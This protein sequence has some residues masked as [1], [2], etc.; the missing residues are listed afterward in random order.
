MWIMFILKSKYGNYFKRV[1]TEREAEMLI[2]KGYTLVEEQT[3]NVD[4]NKMKVSELEA[5]AKAKGI[6][7]SECKNREEKLAKIKEFIE[8]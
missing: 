5:L 7:L 2:K 8:K 6:D 3:E 4:F 1:K